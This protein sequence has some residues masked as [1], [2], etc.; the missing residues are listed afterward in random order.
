MIFDRQAVSVSNNSNTSWWSEIRL[1]WLLPIILPIMG[2][3]SEGFPLES[4]SYLWLPTFRWWTTPGW[5]E[6]LKRAVQARIS[7][8]KMMLSEGCQHFDR[9]DHLG[10]IR[11]SEWDVKD[12]SLQ[13][14]Y[15]KL[16]KLLLQSMPFRYYSAEKAILHAVKS[17]LSVFLVGLY[18]SLR[19][20]H[21]ANVSA[22]VRPK[23][24]ALYPR[25]KL[26]QW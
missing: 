24:L 18:F 25:K 22:L 2:S 1:F 5:L 16:F 26:A 3:A 14:S 17:T 10:T 6:G 19:T 9:G 13:K 12:E 23:Q 4:S 7:L 15:E 21:R 11:Q 20:Q 8:Y